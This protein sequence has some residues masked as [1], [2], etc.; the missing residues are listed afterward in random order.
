M[1]T[2]VAGRLEKLIMAKAQLNQNG[3]SANSRQQGPLNTICHAIP[4]RDCRG[5]IRMQKD[6][7]VW[8]AMN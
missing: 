5:G 6:F 8:C 3:R 2:K 1:Y 4:C 7:K